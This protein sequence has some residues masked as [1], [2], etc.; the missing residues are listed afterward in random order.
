MTQTLSGQEWLTAPA[1]RALLAALKAR[2]SI[3][4]FVGGCVRDAL[5]G[6]QVQ[7]I[8]I[9][10]ADPP[11]VVMDLLKAAGIK[12]IPT[13]LDH[14]TVTAVVQGRPFEVTTLRRDV[15]TTGRHA[16]VAFTEDWEADAARRDFTLNAIYCDPDGTLYDPTG[17]IA[18]L[19]AGRVR[20][21]GNASRRI[22]ED[23]LRILRFFRIYAHFGRAPADADA[24]WA[25]RQHVKGL[26]ILS[27]ERVAH[28][29][30]RLLAAP[31][32]AATLRLM[33]QADVLPAVLP[34]AA[35][36]DRLAA[37]ARID[38]ADIVPVRRLSAAFGISPRAANVVAVRL[39]LSN[40]DRRR[41]LAAAAAAI[42][43]DP[44]VATVRATLYRNG[45]EAFVDQVYLR[46]AEAGGRAGERRFPALLAIANEWSPPRFPL[47]GDDVLALGFERGPKIGELL[48]EVERWWMDGGFVAGR[49]EC[50]ARLRA[51]V[52]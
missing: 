48:S 7:D 31:D 36:L 13:G 9:A 20:F 35:D 17:G 40:K 46:W 52:A 43:P 50:V 5:A 51:L 45:V 21:V 41:L 49:E 18:D 10:T 2:G 19:A 26:A 38:G 33:L 37:L 47:S 1:P 11:A 27:A 8:D 3:V 16:R 29:L 32:P 25:C 44:D 22:E 6:R 15:E 14:G 34:E 42:G 39:K 23:Y 30:L 12:A 4:R 28:E 24:L